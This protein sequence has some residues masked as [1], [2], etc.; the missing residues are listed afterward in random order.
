MK[1]SKKKGQASDCATLLTCNPQRQFPK[2][3]TVMLEEWRLDP[4]R[5]SSWTRL[6]RIQER[7]SARVR[8]MVY[9]MRS[10]DNRK[11]G[12]ELLP[13]EI[14][15]VEEEIVRLAQREAFRDEYL[16]LSAGEPIPSK[17]QLTKLCPKLDEEGYIRSDGRLR[18]AEFLP[19]DARYP[20]ISPRGLWVTK[21]NVK[22]YYELASH[23]ADTNVILTQVSQRYWIIA[24]REE[25]RQWES[26]C[27]TC[28]RR[29]NKAAGQIMA[30]L[31]KERLGFS[32]KPSIQR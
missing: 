27:N 5:F 2:E 25:I 26:E 11:T 13:E 14:K 32:L 16:A 17:S 22:H 29:K 4:K 3:Q 8:R 7:K 28:K 23:S 31:P 6:V 1:T 15:E 24:A 10:K 9:N 20:L 30:P 19:Y 12:R 21:L 18:F